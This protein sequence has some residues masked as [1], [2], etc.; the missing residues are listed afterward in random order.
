MLLTIS[1]LLFY[2]V[3]LYYLY[4][5]YNL[6]DFTYK[7][8]YINIYIIY[9]YIYIYIIYIYTYIYIYIYIYTQKLKETLNSNPTLAAYIAKKVQLYSS[10]SK[11]CLLCL[12]K[13][14]KIINYPPT[15]ELINK[16][17]ELISNCRHAN[18]NKFLLRDYKTKH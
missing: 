15:D 9:I 10:I 1:A 11:K 12:H 4:Y 13:K 18:T 6:L 8:I 2:Y 17:S 14:F 7:Y 3:M 5:L 16:R